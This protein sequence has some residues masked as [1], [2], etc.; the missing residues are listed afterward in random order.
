MKKKGIVPGHGV[1]PD[2][3]YTAIIPDWIV[4]ASRNARAREAYFMKRY[5]S[6]DRM[7]AIDRGKQLDEDAASF[8]EE[9]D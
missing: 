2:L 8:N 6:L 4:K 1:R 7:N 3:E 5:G 9:F